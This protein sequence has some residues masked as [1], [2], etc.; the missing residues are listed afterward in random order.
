[1]HSI[2][3][4]S[5]S[6]PGFIITNSLV[7]TWSPENN[8]LGGRIPVFRCYV[9][10][11]PT[12]DK[13]DIFWHNPPLFST[14]LQMQN[15]LPASRQGSQYID[16]SH[17][18]ESSLHLRSTP[19]HNLDVKPKQ[20]MYFPQWSGVLGGVPIAKEWIPRQKNPGYRMI[21]MCLHTHPQLIMPGPNFT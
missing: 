8:Y 6:F 16:I 17:P 11:P 18:S 19:S 12:V 2:R 4:W 15:A 5:T 1:M 3:R 9:L 10:T 14:P 13:S 20:D 21:S 7:A